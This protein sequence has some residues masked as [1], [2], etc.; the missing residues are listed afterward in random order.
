MKNSLEISL[1]FGANFCFCP[2]IDAIFHWTEN[3]GEFLFTGE[4]LP[5][6]NRGSIEVVN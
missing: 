6:I 3:T 1:N 5:D 4:Y 2:T